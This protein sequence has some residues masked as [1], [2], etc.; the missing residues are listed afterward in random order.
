M[1][2]WKD[3]EGYK[4]IYFVTH[5]NHVKTPHE[6]VVIATV[7]SNN[8][9][10]NMFEYLKEN[11]NFEIGEFGILGCNHFVQECEDFDIEKIGQYKEFSSYD[12]CEETGMRA[13]YIK[14]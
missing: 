8:K 11:E 14:G 13:F 7:Y 9:I 2:K 3:E 12:P 5:Q 6:F 4:Y 10:D 1:Q